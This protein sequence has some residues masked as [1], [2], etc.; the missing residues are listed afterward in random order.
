MVTQ[1]AFSEKF[2]RHNSESHPENAN[3]TTI[4]LNQLK[5][6][7]FYPKLEFIEPKLISEK[8]LHEVHSNRMIRQIKEI[9]ETKDSWIDLDTYVCKNDYETARLAAGSTLQLCENVLQGK[10]ENGFALARPPGHHATPVTSMG[11]CL[12]NNEALAA[13]KLSQDGKKILIFDPDV[14]HGNGIQDAFYGRKDVMYQS[15]HL[16]PHFPGTG[17]IEEIG[18]GNGEG[19]NINAPLGFGNG[20]ESYLSVIDEVM[21]PAAKQFKPDLIIISSG[22]DNHHSDPLGGLACSCNLYGEIIPLFQKVQPKIVAAL[23]G[24]YNLKWIGKCLVNQLG[25]MTGTPITFRDK[26]QGHTR[27]TKKVIS[28]LKNNLS[29]YWSL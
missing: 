20:E 26:D 15:I 25:S 23:E 21:I 17:K 27:G 6:A 3:R 8:T 24:G 11:F 1:I 10:A 28:N 22:Y 2:D 29:S 5:K 16:S 14:H 7:S 19:Y 9:S 4:M 13:Q 18:E 12:F